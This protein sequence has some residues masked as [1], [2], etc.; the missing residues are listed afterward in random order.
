MEASEGLMVV[1]DLATV[2]T[3]DLATLQVL[4]LDGKRGYGASFAGYSPLF[5]R[6]AVIHPQ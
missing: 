3:V 5:S 1:V 6:I 4:Q 2:E